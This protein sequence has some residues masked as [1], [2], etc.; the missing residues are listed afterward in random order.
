MGKKN[1]KSSKGSS[2]LQGTLGECL[3]VFL[4]LLWRVGREESNLQV[5]STL[6][7]LVGIASPWVECVATSV[8]HTACL[9]PACASGIG[10]I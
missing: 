10:G 5:P 6:D 3:A 4:A 1:S 8:Y 7:L 2:S 9:Q